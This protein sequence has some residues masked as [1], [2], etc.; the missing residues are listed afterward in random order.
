MEKQFP[1]TASNEFFS[2]TSDEKPFTNQMRYFRRSRI[3][4]IRLSVTGRWWTNKCTDES[5][6]LQQRHWHGGPGG[7]LISAKEEG[8]FNSIPF[9][10]Q[11]Q[12]SRSLWGFFGDNIHAWS[13]SVWSIPA[14]PMGATHL[15][16]HVS[17]LL[18]HR[19]HPSHQNTFGCSIEA[20]IGDKASPN[21]SATFP[22]HLLLLLLCLK[23]FVEEYWY[24]H[25]LW[26]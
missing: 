1:K 23:A 7:K 5:R 9:H 10:P 2:K 4:M 26:D 13:A 24:V 15:R 25:M 18:I 3:W 8:E 19:V 14:M 12:Y 6:Y 20:V 22:Q 21:T 11:Q 17:T 16:R